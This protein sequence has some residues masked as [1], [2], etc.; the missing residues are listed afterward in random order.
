MILNSTSLTITLIE[1]LCQ[2]G[3][4]VPGQLKESHGERNRVISVVHWDV[5][6]MVHTNLTRLQFH[7]I[8]MTSSRHHLILTSKEFLFQIQNN[9]LIK[10]SFFKYP[11]IHIK[12]S[13]SFCGSQQIILVGIHALG[14]GWYLVLGLQVLFC[15]WLK[16]LA[17][18]HSSGPSTPM[19]HHTPTQETVPQTS[20]FG[21]VCD[22]DAVFNCRV[23]SWNSWSPESITMSQ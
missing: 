20:G 21:E 22:T 18:T 23:G 6:Y 2:R 3:F 4:P 15:S 8:K 9:S 12:F 17:N 7:M 19:Y 5:S 1:I 14:N 16:S 11:R 13:I 10:A